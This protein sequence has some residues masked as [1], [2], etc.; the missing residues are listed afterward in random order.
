M[1]KHVNI[2]NFENEILKSEKVILVDFFATWCG[3]CQMLGPVLENISKEQEDFDIAKLDIDEAQEIA[4]N[5][6]IQVVPTML[7]FKNG[8]VVDSMEGLYS[9]GEIISKVS[10]YLS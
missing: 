7:I 6:G 4:I 2:D 5:Y 9:K 3:P 10:K 1:L 8:Q